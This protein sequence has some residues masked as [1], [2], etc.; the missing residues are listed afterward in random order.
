M[1]KATIPADRLCLIQLENGLDWENI[2]PFLG[3]P[4][5]D[6]PYPGRNEPEKFQA[7]VMDF[8]RPHFIAATMRLSAVAIP[9]VGVLGWAAVKYARGF[10]A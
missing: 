2:C 10:V 3:L 8:F 5:P 9:V 4:I 6:E 1:A 7:L